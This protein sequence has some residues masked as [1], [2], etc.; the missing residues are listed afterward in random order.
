MHFHPSPL[1][2]EGQNPHDTFLSSQEEDALIVS[3]QKA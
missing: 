2:V 3:A 1:Q